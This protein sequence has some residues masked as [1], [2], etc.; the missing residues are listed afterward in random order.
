MEEGL[1][2]LAIDDEMDVDEDVDR[3]TRGYEEIDENDNLSNK[4]ARIGDESSVENKIDII[5]RDVKEIKEIIN[6]SEIRQE[7]Q[8]TVNTM[9]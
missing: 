1:P 7:S 9:E 6:R 4:K 3:Q 5:A 2:K 8:I